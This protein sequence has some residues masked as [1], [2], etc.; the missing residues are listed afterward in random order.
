MEKDEANEEQG[1]EV[2]FFFKARGVGKGRPFFSSKQ[3]TKIK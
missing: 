2:P 3:P 1:K